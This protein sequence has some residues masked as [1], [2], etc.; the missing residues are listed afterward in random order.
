LYVFL[1]RIKPLSIGK[2]KLRD[3]EAR[4]KKLIIIIGDK[5]LK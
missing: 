2:E 4:M 5:L 3:T 1:V